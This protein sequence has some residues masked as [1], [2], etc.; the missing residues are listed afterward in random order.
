MRAGAAYTIRLVAHSP[1]SHNFIAKTF[2]AK[3]HIASEDLAVIRDGTVTFD[4]KTSIDIHL[5][6][7]APGRY[8]FH[9][10]HFMHAALGMRGVIDVQ[11]D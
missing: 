7:P 1:A 3:A 10:G 6:A 4:G 2:L 9:C 5:V 11:P 8:E